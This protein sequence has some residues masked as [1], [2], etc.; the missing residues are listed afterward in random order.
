M[1]YN[2]AK[3]KM[4][5]I[6][7]LTLAGMLSCSSFVVLNATAAFD[8]IAVEMSGRREITVHKITGSGEHGITVTRK[9]YYDEDEELLYVG[10]ESYRVRRN[11][12]YGDGTRFGKYPYCAGEF[13]FYL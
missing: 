2:R 12:R 9:G 7:I 13:Y 1:E 10:K 5:K 6:I 11:P 3:R 4:K 8:P